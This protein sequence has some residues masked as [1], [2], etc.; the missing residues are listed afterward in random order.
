MLKVCS[1]LYHDIK[2]NL[3]IGDFIQMYHKLVIYINKYIYYIN[4]Y[5]LYINYF[6]SRVT[7][8]YF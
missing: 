7:Q 6:M 5:L 4:I 8:F 3:L 2:N 1:K